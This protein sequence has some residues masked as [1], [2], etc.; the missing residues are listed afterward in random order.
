[1]NASQQIIQY[2]N[3]KHEF[4]KM[5]EIYLIRKKKVSLDY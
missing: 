5:M 4:I 3:G 2:E 1:M